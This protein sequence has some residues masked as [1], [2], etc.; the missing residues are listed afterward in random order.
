[1]TTIV[2]GIRKT[3]FSLWFSSGRRGREYVG[4]NINKQAFGE[5]KTKQESTSR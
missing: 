1:M 2:V 4:V 5:R 3:G